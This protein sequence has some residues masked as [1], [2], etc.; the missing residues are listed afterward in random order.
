MFFMYLLA[1]G[2]FSIVFVAIA[3]IILMKKEQKI[4]GWLLPIGIGILIFYCV[5]R[6]FPFIINSPYMVLLVIQLIVCNII[7]GRKTQE[8]SS[9][10][11]EQPE[12]KN[13]SLS[14]TR[15]F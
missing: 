12:M 9:V 4:Y 13:I 2:I 15:D 7:R 8:T 10:E 1:A 5:C 3:Q 14:D 11:E 6:S